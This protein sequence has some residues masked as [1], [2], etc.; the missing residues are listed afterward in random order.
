MVAS[1]PLASGE[2]HH[3]GIRLVFIL[4]T[5]LLFGGY[6]AVHQIFERGNN[7][8]KRLTCFFS[9]EMFARFSSLHGE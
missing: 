1:S 9:V 4:G 8:L 6:I 5:C 2:F 7:G 3:S